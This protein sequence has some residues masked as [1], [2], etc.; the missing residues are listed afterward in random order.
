M[1]TPL[2]F[3]IYTFSV[4]RAFNFAG[5]NYDLHANESQ[6]HIPSQLSVLTFFPLTV[7]QASQTNLAKTGVS[8]ESCPIL[9][10]LLFS[11]PAAIQFSKIK[12]ETV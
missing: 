2:S 9:C 4:K 5:Y 7:S 10:A 1:L 6:D 12:G 3:L 8:T 11:G